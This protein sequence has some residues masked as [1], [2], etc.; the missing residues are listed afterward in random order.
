M[1]VIMM[2]GKIKSGELMGGNSLLTCDVM[3][4]PGNQGYL[5]EGTLLTVLRS[6][7]FLQKPLTP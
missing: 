3:G 7:K 6:T 2:K 1:L 5:K 4:E